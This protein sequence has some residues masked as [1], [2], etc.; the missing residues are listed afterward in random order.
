[1]TN[2]LDVITT[3]HWIYFYTCGNTRLYD[4]VSCHPGCVCT[5]R[6]W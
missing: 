2:V 4:V 1:M 5:L 6:T 3:G